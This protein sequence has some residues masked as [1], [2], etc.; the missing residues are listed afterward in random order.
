MQYL[1]A[2]SDVAAR[3]NRDLGE[4]QQQELQPPPTPEER[5]ERGG[6]FGGPPDLPTHGGANGGGGSNDDGGN[7]AQA[8]TDERLSTIPEGTEP[9][10]TDEHTAVSDDEFLDARSLLTLFGDF[11]NDET[12][13]ALSSALSD[14]SSVY[15]EADKQSELDELGCHLP[16]LSGETLLSSLPV[17]EQGVVQAWTPSLPDTSQ[18]SDEKVYL[19]FPG[20]MAKLID[21]VTDDLPIG[22]TYAI[23][24]DSVTRRK[25]IV[26]TD[27]D[28]LTPA[29]IKEHRN[30]VLEAQRLELATWHKHDCFARRP[31]KHARNVIDCRWV[32]KWKGGQPEPLEPGSPVTRSERRDVARFSVASS[33][34]K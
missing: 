5:G 22:Q 31:R 28:L 11:D 2:D 18:D 16:E 25:Q 13:A 4:M 8:H 1:V 3:V 9:S 24:Q 29:E 20:E 33:E 27:S 32:L 10:N 14:T 17:L 7:E 12:Y 21:G 30:D 23:A 19:E 6:G 15:V 34:I 26:S